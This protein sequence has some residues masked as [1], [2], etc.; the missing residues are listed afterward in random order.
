[1]GSEICQDRLVRHMKTDEWVSLG[2]QD[3]S[4]RGGEGWGEP[5]G[6]RH[7]REGS[8]QFTLCPT[9]RNVGRI[10][11][12]CREKKFLNKSGRF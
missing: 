3:T 7:R 6:F 12:S 1:M 8:K 10:M 11:Q 2:T 9:R 4:Q 5:Y